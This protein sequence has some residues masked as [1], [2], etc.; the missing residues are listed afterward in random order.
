MAEK[1][2]APGSVR[3]CPKRI[4][5]RAMEED[6]NVP[7]VSRAISLPIVLGGLAIHC[8]GS[9]LSGRTLSFTRT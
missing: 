4:G 8:P 6:P 2:P 1:Q 7:S 9:A 3:P 5:W